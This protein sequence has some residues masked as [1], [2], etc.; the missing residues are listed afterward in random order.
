MPFEHYTS[1]LRSTLA[2]ALDRVRLEAAASQDP[3]PRPKVETVTTYFL[4][5]PSPGSLNALEAAMSHGNQ[6]VWSFT[7]SVDRKVGTLRRY[8]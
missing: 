6:A 7:P 2:E 3:P 1:D 4:V 5:R 8:F